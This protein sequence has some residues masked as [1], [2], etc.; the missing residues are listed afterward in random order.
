[1]KY[2]SIVKLNLIEKQKKIKIIMKYIMVIFMQIIDLVIYIEIIVINI[3]IALVKIISMN[4]QIIIYQKIKFI[5]ITKT[6]IQY[7]IAIML[8]I[9]IIST[10]KMMKIMNQKK[11]SPIQIFPNI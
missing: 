2:L 8:N 10:K 9:K 3:Q 6:L 7:I 4:I 1:M 11:K 5:L